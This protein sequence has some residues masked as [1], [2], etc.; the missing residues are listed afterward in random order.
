MKQEVL[1]RRGEALFRQV[2]TPLNQMLGPQHVR[3]KETFEEICLALG[4]LEH[5]MIVEMKRRT[6]L[7][8]W[9]DEVEKLAPGP[10]FEPGSSD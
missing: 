1:K 9:I 5:Q 10:G 3:S 8:Q 7:Y 2:V 6:P 4:I